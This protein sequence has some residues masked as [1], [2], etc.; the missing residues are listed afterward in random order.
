M[1]LLQYR[2]EF[3]AKVILQSIRSGH[4]VQHILRR[5]KHGS[6]SAQLALVPEKKTQYAFPFVPHMP[7]HLLKTKNPY[8]HSQMY[9]ALLLGNA[10]LQ[11]DDAPPDAVIQYGPAPSTEAQYHVPFHGARIVEP[12]L[13]MA[14]ASRWT[15]IPITDDLFRALLDIY[16]VNYHPTLSFFHKDF[17]LD[18]L[19]SGREQ[20]CSA[21]LVNAILAVASVSERSVRKLVRSVKLTRCSTVTKGSPSAPSFGTWALSATCSYPKRKDCGTTRLDWRN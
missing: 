13:G 1:D 4:D 18:D 10:D 2:P 20:H 15:T 14:R 6:L 12:R 3:E 19:I 16:L 7:V 21:L 11:P 17:F 9:A 8:L 5:F